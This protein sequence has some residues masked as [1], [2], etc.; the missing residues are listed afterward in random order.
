[1]PAETLTFEEATGGPPQSL[2]WEDVQDKLPGESYAGLPPLPPITAAKLDAAAAPMS[3]QQAAIEL[4]PRDEFAPGPIGMP[5]IPKLGAEGSVL[6][7]VTQ[8]GAGA[9]EAIAGGLSGLTSREGMATLPVFAVPYVGPGLALGLGAKGV[10]AGLGEY[11]AGVEQADPLAAGRGAGIAGLNALMLAGGA[12]GIPRVELPESLRAAGEGVEGTAP[13]L[14]PEGY[15]VLGGGRFRSKTTPP[16][17]AINIGKTVVTKG[18]RVETTY[19]F[20]LPPQQVP[21]TEPPPELGAPTV[22][23][24]TAPIAGGPSAIQEPKAGELLQDVRAPAGQGEQ[25]VSAAQGAEGVRGSEQAAPQPEVPLAEA[26]PPAE[27]PSLTVPDYDPQGIGARERIKRRQEAGATREQ[28]VAGDAAD[29]DATRKWVDDNTR[30]G[31]VIEASNGRRYRRDEEGNWYEIQDGKVRSGSRM[32]DN[33]GFR[34]GKIVQ[35]GTK[36]RTRDDAVVEGEEAPAPPAEAPK[37]APLTPAE[38]A[39]EPAARA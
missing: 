9:Q 26:A 34:G 38:Q 16:P 28:A 24:P 8:F 11:V 10:G 30:E 2:S 35:R 32:G 39:A 7:D 33:S 5:R 23:Q 15:E 6:R 12:R 18:G 20:R 27:A 17:E 31:D 4:M 19:D 14:S 29:I 3:W 25:A 13:L 22:P 21:S 37:P 36:V 1:M